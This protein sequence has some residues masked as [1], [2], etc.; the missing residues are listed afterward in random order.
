MENQHELDRVLEAVS[1]IRCQAVCEESELHA[2]VMRALEEA[3]LSPQHEVK[4]APRCRI[5]ILCGD[6]G[7]EIKKS[8]P[9]PAALRGQLARYAACEQIEQLVVIAPRGVNLPR[10]IGGKRVTMVAL[11]R[12]WG[13][14]LP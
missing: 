5:D 4:I 9:Q 8:R 7:I 2:Q 10:V 3:G 11:E 14:S 12:L 13:V 6:V 1:V